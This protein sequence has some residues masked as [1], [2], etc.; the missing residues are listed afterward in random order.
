MG[1]MDSN[2]IA[3]AGTPGTDVPEARR[4]AFSLFSA[5]R[6]LAPPAPGPGNSLGMGDGDL[7]F[8]SPIPIPHPPTMSSCSTPTPRLSAMPSRRWCAI[9][10]R[11][12]MLQWLGR[13]CA[14]PMAARSPRAAA[15]PPKGFTSGRARR[16]SSAGRTTPGRGATTG[17]HA[18]RHRARGRLAGRRGAAGAPH[19]NRARRPAR[20]RLSMYS[21]EL[22]WQ[23]QDLGDGRWGDGGRSRPLQPPLLSPISPRIMY[24]PDA[25]I[26][27]HEGKSS[28]QAL[29]QRYLNFQHSRLRDARMVY[30]QR[31]AARC[32]CSCAR[33]TR[34]SW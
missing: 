3:L 17:R 21:E 19:R 33:P 4:E 18:R 14:T 15:F 5:F 23:R 34:P 29:A 16:W 12:P 6:A 32:G 10:R 25:V 8:P 20:R 26:I 1:E 7:H 27:H 30:G 28:E 24:L 9:W 2:P 11:I 22:E 13:S 31:F